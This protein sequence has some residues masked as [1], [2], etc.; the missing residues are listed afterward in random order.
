MLKFH[1]AHGKEGTLTVSLMSLGFSTWLSLS[2]Q[3]TTVKDPSKYGVI[4]HDASGKIERFVEK[5]KEYV[6]NHINAGM[7]I[8]N[9]EILQRIKVCDLLGASCWCYA[10]LSCALFPSLRCGWVQ[11]PVEGV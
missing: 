4:V 10:V 1:R 8:F 3:V 7:Y 2:W 9:P 11:L 5:P 6:G